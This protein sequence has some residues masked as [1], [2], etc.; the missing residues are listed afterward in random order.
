MQ[1]SNPRRHYA[2]RPLLKPNIRSLMIALATSTIAFVP[3]ANAEGIC[4]ANPPVHVYT[5]WEVCDVFCPNDA[6][7]L[8]FRCAAPGTGYDGILVQTRSNA[9][10]VILRANGKRQTNN[11]ANGCEALSTFCNR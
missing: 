1:K 4:G 2:T 6:R 9:Y 10:Y 3:I 5:N 7:R 11:Y 8:T